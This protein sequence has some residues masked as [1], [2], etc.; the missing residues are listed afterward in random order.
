MDCNGGLPSRICRCLV[1]HPVT[2]V[3]EAV[4]LVEDFDLHDGGVGRPVRGIRC[5]CLWGLAK[6]VLVLGWGDGIYSHW[7]FVSDLTSG[8][9]ITSVMLTS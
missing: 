9:G 1:V 6:E 5:E 3:V 2:E 8:V 4:Q 7:F